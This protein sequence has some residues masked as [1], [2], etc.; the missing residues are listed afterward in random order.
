MTR[1]RIRFQVPPLRDWR[2]FLQAFAQAFAKFLEAKFARYPFPGRFAHPA[3]AHRIL[4][5]LD[6]ASAT[7]AALAGSTSKPCSPDQNKFSRSANARTYNGFAAH[8]SF[9]KND[10]KPFATRRHGRP[11]PFSPASRRHNI[12]HSRRQALSGETAPGS[13]PTERFPIPG[14]AIRAGAD[15]RRRRRSNIRHRARGAKRC[16]ML[17]A[18]H[19]APYN[20]RMTR[21]DQPLGR[22]AADHRLIDVGDVEGGDVFSFGRVGGRIRACGLS[23]GLPRDG[24]VRA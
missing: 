1:I 7:S 4:E 2:L 21:S 9:Q 5:Q 6:Q 20:V 19:R 23:E 3:R 13:A 24:R 10:A 22:P 8:H 16:A 12:Y 18:S 11:I 17:Q 15:H 14:R